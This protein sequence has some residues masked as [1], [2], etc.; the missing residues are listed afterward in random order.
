MDGQTSYQTLFPPHESQINLFVAAHEN[1]GSF[2]VQSLQCKNFGISSDYEF[3]VTGIVQT[4]LEL[5]QLFSQKAKIEWFTSS[6]SQAIHGIINKVIDFGGGAAGYRYQFC[7][8]S[9]LQLLK[10][11][12]N[13]QIFL[14]KTV[15]E[16]I[17]TVLQ[18]AGWVNPAYQINCV[19]DYPS[20]P[21]T[22][23]F[24]E[25]DFDFLLRL[26]VRW[27][28]FFLFEQRQS[29]ACL[30]IY[31]DWQH[32]PAAKV[33]LPF[34]MQSGQVSGTATRLSFPAATQC[35]SVFYIIR[36][37]HL[38]SHLVVLQD[39][40]T[41]Q[42]EKDLRSKKSKQ[43]TLA[44]EGEWQYFGGHFQNEEEGQFLAALMQDQID[45]QRDI[46]K[47]ITDARNL[48]PGQILTLTNHP[49]DDFNCAYR[50]I[51]IATC[52]DQPAGMPDLISDRAAAWRSTVLLIP[53]PLA[54]RSQIDF[55]PPAMAPIIEWEQHR[56]L[57]LLTKPTL[58]PKSSSLF[59][60]SVETINDDSTRAY[61]DE[62]GRYFLRQS[63]DYSD[64]LR[65][66]ASSPISRVQS[67]GGLGQMK[68]F[69]YGCHFPLYPES[70]VAVAHLFG[71]FDRP[72]IIG[73]VPNPTTPSSV[74]A[75]NYTEHRLM[76]PTGQ[77]LIFDDKKQQQRI[78]LAT[79]QQ[80]NQFLLSAAED[81]PFILLEAKQGRILLAAKQDLH[82]VAQ[83]NFMIKVAKSK[84]LIVHNDQHV[85]SKKGD[86][87]HYSEGEIVYSSKGDMK[88]QSQ[89]S[90]IQIT[91][92]KNLSIE[93]KQN[94]KHLTVKGDQHIS[95]P[96]GKC[97]LR[98]KTIQIRSR[99]L[100][101]IMIGHALAALKI[102][103]NKSLS[104]TGTTLLLEAP[105]IHIPQ[106]TIINA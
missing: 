48:G 15:I 68:G 82:M 99:G 4:P 30:N 8:S 67:Y 53:I 50:I 70:Y 55:F 81:H 31:D 26:C 73:A 6:A 41:L 17:E 58:A 63:F 9:P 88:W 101:S 35:A 69:H 91:S 23:Q 32:Y 85:I 24:N 25:S 93:T 104:I 27:G 47:C 71:N 5:S 54:Y 79:T 22:V 97:Q 84:R 21:Y 57:S 12:H 49:D 62:W 7:L 96:Q 2:Q 92:K 76:T 45:G 60:A 44:S 87:L 90:D 33:T 1:Q 100:E 51:N 11:R 39:I 77:A 34:V 46:Y 10:L 19:Q 37:T 42:P 52:F 38:L 65:G 40:N 95:I 78:E 74:T 105:M 61:L 94:F 43:S 86:H 103:P 29:Y 72:I 28:L 106:F 20:L 59:Y 83:S 36:A 56:E 16:I 18:K 64:A 80:Q 66:Q 14:N 89:Q 13:H 102:G 98:A 3:Y 75:A